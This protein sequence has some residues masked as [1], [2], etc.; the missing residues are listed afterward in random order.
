MGE[1][2]ERV[3]IN[4]PGRINLLLDGQFQTVRLDDL[5]DDKL[6]QLYEKGCRYVQPTSA[7]IKKI[8]PD[9]KQ[10]K[11]KEIKPLKEIPPKKK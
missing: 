6:Q 3:G 9:E 4:A 11:I 5:P 8:F 7:G 1:L 10:I 2:F